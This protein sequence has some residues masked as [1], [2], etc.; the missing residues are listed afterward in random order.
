MSVRARVFA[1]FYRDDHRC[2]L[3]GSALGIGKHQNTW[4]GIR[5]MSKSGPKLEKAGRG[6]APPRLHDIHH[7]CATLA[8]HSF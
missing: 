4:S 5:W 7:A 6:D 2:A 1:P 8:S 3:S